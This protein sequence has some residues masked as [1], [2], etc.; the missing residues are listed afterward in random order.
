MCFK[1]L[2]IV[3]TSLTIGTLFISTL[4]SLRID[5]ARIGSVAFFEP[6]ILNVPDNCFFPY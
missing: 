3:I 2:I 1:R 5:A 6:D 4:S